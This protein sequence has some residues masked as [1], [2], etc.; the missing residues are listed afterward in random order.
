MQKSSLIKILHT[1]ENLYRLGL[2]VF[3]FSFFPGIVFLI[4]K[5]L[6]ESHTS[7][8]AFYSKFYRSL[9][10]LGMDGLYSWSVACAPY[11]AYDIY[12]LIKSNKAKKIDTGNKDD[13]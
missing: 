11:I 3:G 1:R 8:P 12:L 13:L 4:S 7:M 2:A 9:L 10:N 5:I 6:F